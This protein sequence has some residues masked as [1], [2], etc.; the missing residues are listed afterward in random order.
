MDPEPLRCDR[1]AARYATVL[2]MPG[3]KVRLLISALVIAGISALVIA[4]RVHG[5]RPNPLSPH[6]TS[7]AV[8]DGA[9]ITITYGRPSMRG[10]KI[11]GSLLPYDHWW[12]PGADESTK[13]ETSEALQFGDFKLPAGAYT[14]YTIPGRDKWTLIINRRTGQ[15]HTQYPQ[16]DDLV[17]LPMTLEH[18]KTPVER[19]TIEA[20]PR[21]AGGAL[22]LEWENTRVSVPFTVPR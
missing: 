3:L 14:L 6:E 4:P 5:Q 7:T 10:R 16:Q 8:I 11:F 17:K 20:V 18:L 19:L 1:L 21:A 2:R 15:F 12:M 13:V 22:Q 9:R